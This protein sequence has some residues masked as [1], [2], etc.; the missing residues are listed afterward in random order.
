M[1][2]QSVGWQSVERAEIEIE[3]EAFGLMV[4]WE[5]VVEGLVKEGHFL[6]AYGRRRQAEAQRL[7][8]TDYPNQQ[9]GLESA[10][11]LN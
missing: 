5:Q 7:N 11:L 9:I 4:G 10:Q 8:R 2:W 6:V 1:Q 3:K